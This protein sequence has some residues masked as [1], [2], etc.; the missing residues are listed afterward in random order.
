MRKTT[1]VS[2]FLF[3]ALALLNLSAAQS[4][5]S[6]ALSLANVAVM[7]SQVVAGSNVTVLFQLYNSYGSSLTNVNLQLTGSYPLLNFSPSGTYMLSSIGSGLYPSAISYTI[8]IPKTTPTGVYTLSMVGT[9]QTISSIYGQVV[10]SSVMPLSIYVNGIPNVTAVAGS[11]PVTPGSSMSLYAHIMN[12]GYDTAKNVVVR[13]LNT[14]SFTPYGVSTLSISSL[15][16]G[17]SVNATIS[18]QVAKSV[19]NGTYSLPLTVSYQSGTGTQYTKIINLTESVATVSPQIKLSFANPMPQALFAGYNQ[20]VQLQIQ[21]IGNGVARNVSVSLSAGPGTNLLGSVV[22][23]FVSTLQ[24]GQTVSDPVLLSASGVGSASVNASVGYYSADYSKSFSGVQQLSLSLAPAAQFTVTGQKSSLTPGSTD[25]PITFI[26]KNT[27]TIAAQGAQF[28]LQSTY[29]ITPIAGTY[30]L[31]DLPAGS[32]ANVTFL[33]SV[34]TQGVPSSY[35][36][37]LFEQWKQ[38]NGAANQQFSGSNSYFISVGGGGS[39]LWTYGI[40]VV[41]IAAAGAYVFMKRRKAKPKAAAE[42]G[43]GK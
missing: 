17:A 12:S 15:P 4:T 26:V 19:R 41:V 21:N 34:D 3:A 24:P 5:Q 31:S 14:S 13:A 39:S 6:G 37:T 10:G 35:P 11:T 38:P 42:K 7:P 22:S 25:L 9:Y 33:V 36:V 30:Y 32:S 27:G 20:T 40:V 43:H 1:A 18:Y 23:F 28:S 8:R 29:P 16:I 2:V